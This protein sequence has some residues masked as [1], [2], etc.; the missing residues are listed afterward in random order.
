MSEALR[1]LIGRTW[2]CAASPDRPLP[3]ERMFE[4]C[5]TVRSVPSAANVQPWEF[6]LV[7]DADHRRALASCLLDPFLRP[8]ASA[9]LLE[10]APVVLVAAVDRKRAGARHGELGERLLAVQD[11]AAAIVCLRLAAARE[12]IGSAWP[13]EVD[14]P[15]AGSALHLPRGLTVVA[16][17]SF[18]YP[19]QFPEAV[20]GMPVGEWLHVL[21]S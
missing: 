14:L 2:D 18:G 9:G 12:G 15:R 5:E 4:L 3:L 17:L 11:T 19:A 1:E 8:Q 21:D 6:Y 20:A 13:R 16:V 10:S 7:Q